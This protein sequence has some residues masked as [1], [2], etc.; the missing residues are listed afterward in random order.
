[1]RLAPD[2]AARVYAVAADHYDGK[3]HV[4]RPSSFAAREGADVVINGGFFG[5]GGQHL[6]TFIEDGFVRAT[7]VFPNRPMLV[8]SNSGQVQIGRYS[9][10]T[11]LL[12]DDGKGGGR[13]RIPIYGKNYPFERGRV[14]A[15]DGSYPRETLP[16]GGMFY[17]MLR[18]DKLSYA[19]EDPATADLS[20]G[21]LLIATD[22][23]PEANPLQGI[24][25]EAKVALETK[26][27]DAGGQAVLARYAIGG[28]PLLVE[29]GAVNISTAED[30]IKSDI[31]T[32]AR[33][34]TAA[35]L[36]R[37]GQLLLV[38]VK[39]DESSGYSGVTLEQLAQ[40]LV[41][42]G[43]VTALNF[44]GGG[45]SAMVVGG[46]LLNEPDAQERPVSNVLVVK[47]GG[48]NTV[49]SAYPP[50]RHDAA[51]P[52]E[53]APAAPPPDPGDSVPVTKYDR[54]G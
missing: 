47:A 16:K 6:T 4:R 12:V 25:P 19:G 14:I 2:A 22:I 49:A 29:N 18:G 24:G 21:T 44:D 10:E 38:V 9:P 34:R 37:S 52:P 13:K 35:A 26:L 1:V 43:A 20:G 40:L 33:S 50:A 11:A 54:G 23:M 48:G 15:Y 7:G 46:A 51:A 5:K 32:G 42:E 39:E 53:A 8:V 28:G 45:S 3:T 41:S 17:Y 31:S 27:T 30:S 36:T